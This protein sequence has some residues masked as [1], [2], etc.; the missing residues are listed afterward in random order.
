[1]FK[2]F[3]LF[4]KYNLILFLVDP[5]DDRGDQL[6][7]RDVF[8]SRLLHQHE[9]LSDVPHLKLLVLLHSVDFIH[10]LCESELLLLYYFLELLMVLRSLAGLLVSFLEG[11][12][13]VFE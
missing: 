8:V 13:K 1:M 11:A 12:Y 5:L 2:L 7:A 9:L 6:K 4:I 3:V 10:K